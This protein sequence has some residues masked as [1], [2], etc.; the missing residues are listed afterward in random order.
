MVKGWK[1]NGNNEWRNINDTR[2]FVTISDMGARRYVIQNE[3]GFNAEGL[4]GIVSSKVKARAKATNYMRR[5]PRGRGV[6]NSK[7]VNLLRELASEGL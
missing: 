7:N 4:I 1:K 6:V 3:K 5:Y 2:R